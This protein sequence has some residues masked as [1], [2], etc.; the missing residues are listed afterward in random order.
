VREA[1][2]VFTTLEGAELSLDTRSVFAAVPALH[3]ELRR[4]F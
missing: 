2:G 3:R 1:G 4:R